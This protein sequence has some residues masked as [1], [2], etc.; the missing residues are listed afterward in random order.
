MRRHG[1]TGLFT[2]YRISYAADEREVGFGGFESTTHVVECATPT[3]GERGGRGGRGIGARNATERETV[4]AEPARRRGD[5]DG[6]G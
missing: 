3:V 6:R 1:G 2:I 5:A 4:D